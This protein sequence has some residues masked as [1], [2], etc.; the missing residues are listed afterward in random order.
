MVSMSVFQANV[1][2]QDWSAGSSLGW[3][4]N[5][6]HEYPLL[7]FSGAHYLGFSLGTPVSSTALLA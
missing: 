4:L 7:A 5:F 2:Q 3:A 6:G 1:C